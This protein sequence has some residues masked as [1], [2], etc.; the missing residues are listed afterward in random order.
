MRCPQSHKEEQN[1]KQRTNHGLPK[2]DNLI[3]YR[4]ENVGDFYCRL[5]QPWLLAGAIGVKRT[6]V[7]DVDAVAERAEG[8]S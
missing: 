8:V 3:R 2:P 1:Q 5:S 7:V 6:E 4:H